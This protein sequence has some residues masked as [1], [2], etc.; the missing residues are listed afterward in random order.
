MSQREQLIEQ[1]ESELS[2]K[3]KIAQRF[4]TSPTEYPSNFPD[5]GKQKQFEMNIKDMEENDKKIYDLVELLKLIPKEDTETIKQKRAFLVQSIQ[6][7]TKQLQQLNQKKQVSQHELMN[8]VLDSQ[9]NEVGGT[10][11]GLQ[12]IL[13][14]L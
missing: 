1:L 6:D 4:Q 7:K 10:I 5:P 9:L 3:L 8:R 11:N 12:K 13:L 14:V 2:T